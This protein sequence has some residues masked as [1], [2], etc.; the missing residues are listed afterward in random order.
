MRLVPILLPVLGLAHAAFAAAEADLLVAYDNGYADSVGGDDNAEVICAN[1]VAASNWINANSGTGARMRIA[2]Y[3]KTWWQAGRST[4]GGYVGWLWNYGDGYLDDVT[5]AADAIGADLVA[6]ICEPAAGEGAAAVAHQPGRYAAYGPG[7][8]WNN[9]VAHE[10]GGHN[11]GCDHRGGRESP[12]TIML[13]NYCGG[14]SREYYSNPNIWLDGTRLSGEGSCLGAAVDG[15]DN[16]YLIST[17][18]QGVADRNERV[19]RGSDIGA[20]RYRW[21]FNRPAGAAPAGTVISGTGGDAVVRGNGATFTGTALRLPGGTTGNTAGSSIAAYIDLPNGIF[22]AMPDF[23]I[24]VWAAPLAARNWMRVIDIGRTTEAGDG[25]GADGEYTATPASP[26]PGATSSRDNLMLSACIGTDLNRQRLEGKLGGA[27]V[28]TADSNLATTAG[29]LHHYAITFTDTAGGGTV[30]WYRDGAL[31]KALDTAFHAADL[32]DVNNWL[33]RSLWSGDD[34]ANIDYHE[35]RI[36][37]IALADGNVAANCLIGP[38][39]AKATLWAHDGWANSGF[40]SGA[41]EFGSVPSP[42]RDYET[43]AMR[44]LA[45]WT[46]TDS[47]FPGRSLTITGGSLYLAAKDSNTVT[48]HDLRLNRGTI[49]SFGDNG[50]TQTLAGQIHVTNFTD[51]HVRG[52]WGPLVIVANLTGG[53]GGG[54]MLYTENPVT[55]TGDNTGYLGATIIGDGRFS[56]LRIGSET[57]LGGNPTYYGGAWLQLNRGILE[58][59]ATMT[60]DDANR[61]IVIGPSGGIFRPAAGT[62]LTI[63]TTLN[64]PAAGNTLQTAPMDSN[65]IQGIFFKEGG[66]TLVLTHPN[67]SHNAEMQIQQGELRLE[68]G[69][70]INNGDHWMP[71]TLNS[72]LNYNSTATQTLRGAIS[73]TGSLVKNN[74][75]TLHVNGS[76]TFSGGVTV[77]GGTLYANPGNAATDRAFSHVSGITVNTGAT[78]KAGA[79]GL[80]GW[81]GTQARPVAVNAGGTLTIDAA[82]ADVNVGTVTLNGG[83]L[84]GGPSTAWGS[85]N[86]GR[87]AS[88][89]PGSG[90]L[91]V[92]ADSTATATGLMFHHGASIDVAAGRTLTIS[93]SLDDATSEGVCSLVKNGTGTLTLSGANTFTGPADINAGTLVVNGS[94]A[95]GSTVTIAGAATLGGTG[96]IGGPA[97]IHGTHSPGT[98]AGTQRFG[99]TLGYGPTA[100]LQWELVSNSTAAGAGDRV[101]ASGAV[102]I[103]GGAKVDVVLNAPASGVALDGAFWTQPRSWTILTGAGVTGDFTLGTVTGDPAGR[104]LAGHGTLALQ[105]DATSVTLVFTP[106]TASELWRLAHF[107]TTSGSGTAADAADPDHDALPNLLEYALGC[108]PTAP[109]ASSAP[110]CSTAGGRLRITF[111]RNTAAADITLA[112]VAADDVAGPWAEVARSTNGAPFTAVAP[113]AVVNE[114]GSGGLRDVEAIDIFLITDPAHPR[115][116]MRVVVSR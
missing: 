113:G 69:G 68:G 100:R 31:V 63:A 78:L 40:F 38:N 87:A 83:T 97:T 3:H 10:T 2:G 60:I 89:N 115:R 93:G 39:D 70:R 35:V 62:T 90:R 56:T 107:G 53:V 58:T 57:N 88:V 42:A 49:L 64:S 91:V 114:T 95:A 77:N 27:N 94:L 20:I 50:S 72:T 43:G 18:A 1:A 65:P 101:T 81:D 30:K 13:H 7:N 67:N 96:T 102:T 92:T 23:T 73:G 28:V 86:F 103:A 22:S 41:W 34:M 45:P 80:F 9:V 108:D 55:L 104:Q 5:A 11:Y 47:T 17:T 15:G 82:G 32:D 26:A 33:G 74:T 116:F 24:E 111:T 44:L 52:A 105:Q 16:A 51:N 99:G 76:N 59:T 4:L 109:S 110:R 48:I 75:G 37:D 36:Q 79:N 29:E 112:V 106:W 21:Q 12:K 66:G 8:F 71:V 19:A 25:T 84:A 54:G 46:T 6:Y 98:G 85:W 61:G 14:G